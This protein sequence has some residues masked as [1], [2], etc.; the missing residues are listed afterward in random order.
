MFNESKRPI[1]SIISEA[2]MRAP[3]DLI[4][5]PIWSN[6]FRWGCVSLEVIY[7][8]A[9]AVPW[10]FR[11]APVVR[12]PA[13]QAV[14]YT[15]CPHRP[16]VGDP[17]SKQVVHSWVGCKAID[18]PADDLRMKVLPIWRVASHNRGFKTFV[19]VAV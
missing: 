7:N 9:S 18:C 4:V 15:R 3:S 17:A 19:V 6:V 13:K 8:W 10:T 16:N 11:T 14:R 12:V 5:F 1:S 2:Y